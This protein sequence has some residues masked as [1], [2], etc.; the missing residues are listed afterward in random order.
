MT[1]P[2]RYEE[3]EGLIVSAQQQQAVMV[4]TFRCTISFESAQAT[5]PILPNQGMG[6]VASRMQQRAKQSVWWSIRRSLAT[7]IRRK[8]GHGILGQLGAE[9]AG[10]ALGAAENLSEHT[11]TD[12]QLR[13]ATV[14][15]FEQVRDR[16]RWDARMDQWVW[17]AAP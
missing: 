3:I 15:A 9:L 10:E 5:V 13:A 2:V 4:C 16:F 12:A 11:Y 7:A 8:F 1:R 14:R 6:G 17:A